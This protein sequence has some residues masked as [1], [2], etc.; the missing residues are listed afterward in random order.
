LFDC[1]K[2][3]WIT[4]EVDCQLCCGSLTAS[5]LSSASILPDDYEKIMKKFV[6]N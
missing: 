5:V 2:E 6:G 3:R 4:D 1:G